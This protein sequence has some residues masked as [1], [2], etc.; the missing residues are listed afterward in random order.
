MRLLTNFSL[1]LPFPD[2]RFDYK[3]DVL[4][5]DPVAIRWGDDLFS[6]YR[7]ISEKITEI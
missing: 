5:F 6:H 3:E 7:D 1:S 4:C 2:G